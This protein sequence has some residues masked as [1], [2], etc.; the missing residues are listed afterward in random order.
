MK[1]IYK[2]KHVQI[3]KLN[4]RTIFNASQILKGCLAGTVAI[5]ACFPQAQNGQNRWLVM[6]F[7]NT[8]EILKT[9][10]NINREKFNMRNI[11]NQYEFRNNIAHADASINWSN[12]TI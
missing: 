10:F 4:S 1:Y 12:I 2:D 11:G 5:R 7:R 9:N 8:L 3:K 6:E